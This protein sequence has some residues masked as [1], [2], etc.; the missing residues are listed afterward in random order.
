MIIE[1]KFQKQY[2]DTETDCTQKQIQE[3]LFL[4]EPGLIGLQKDTAVTHPD[5]VWEEL[6]CKDYCYLH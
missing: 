5:F 2:D 1:W 4:I 6:F 3:T